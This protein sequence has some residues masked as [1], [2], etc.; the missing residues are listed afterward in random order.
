MD[1]LGGNLKS[2]SASYRGPL[3][4]NNTRREEILYEICICPG[5]LQV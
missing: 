5:S 3:K 4:S 1:V 2:W